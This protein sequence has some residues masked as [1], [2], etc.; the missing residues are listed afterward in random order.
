MLPVAT[1]VHDI[2][3]RLV[4]FFLS[5]FVSRRSSIM[6]VCM[7]NVNV[8]SVSALFSVLRR[9]DQEMTYVCLRVYTVSFVVLGALSILSLLHPIILPPPLPPLWPQSCIDSFVSSHRLVLNYFFVCLSLSVCN[10][11]K[12]KNIKVPCTPIHTHTDK[13]THLKKKRRKK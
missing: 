2:F 6:C 3:D 1:G 7:W 4:L 12:N 13:P 9:H 8:T 11:E 5:L 10:K